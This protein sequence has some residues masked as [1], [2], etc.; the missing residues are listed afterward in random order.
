MA[1]Y[2]VSTSGNDS[3]AGTTPGAPFATVQKGIDSTADGDTL[4][5]GNDGTHILS[6]AISW[7]TSTVSGS[8]DAPLTITSWDEN[9]TPPGNFQT[10]ASSVTDENDFPIAVLS[11]NDSIANILTTTGQPLYVQW[12]RIK[13]TSTTSYLCAFQQRSYIQQCEFT[14]WGGSTNGISLGTYSS[15]DECYVHNNFQGTDSA[16]VFANTAHSIIRNSVIEKCSG[17][18]Y[19]TSSNN[20]RIENCIIRECLGS[21]IHATGSSKKLHISNNTLIGATGLNHI[22]VEID[23]GSQNHIILNNIIAKFN[24]SSGY[25]IRYVGSGK[26]SIV[27]YNRFWDN[28]SGANIDNKTTLLDFTSND[29]T[30]ATD[31]FNGYSSGDYSVHADD[32]ASGAAYPQTYLGASGAQPR[33]NIGAG[34]YLAPASPPSGNEKTTTFYT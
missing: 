19:E 3:N 22:G 30:G 9:S 25:G 5:I 4:H 8:A 32:D 14:D 33:R 31:P 7:A 26:S 21:C 20:T 1:D 10:R 17:D 11:G 12:N 6:S 13:F 28:R 34:G 29:L 24:G 16:G 27:G 15:M 2:Y 23:T 18:G